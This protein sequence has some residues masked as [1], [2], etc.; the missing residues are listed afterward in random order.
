MPDNGTAVLDPPKAPTP[1]T[2]PAIVPVDP[3][4]PSKPAPPD[5][6]SDEARKLAKIIEA[7][8]EVSRL[9]T[10]HLFQAEIAKDAKKEYEAACQSLQR[11]IRQMGEKLPL[12]DKPEPPKEDAWRELA[13]D[14]LTNHGLTVAIAATLEKAGIAT[15]GAMSDWS[16]SNK[17]L[18][19]IK[20]IGQGKAEQILAAPNLFWAAWDGKAEASK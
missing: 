17:M 1:F 12:F 3:P 4:E 8:V 19:E 15:M 18:T 10:H 2:G 16:D 5:P 11:L 14:V 6:P 7:N 9:Q 13:I 20:G